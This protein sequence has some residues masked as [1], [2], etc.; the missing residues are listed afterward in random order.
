[1]RD[2]TEANYNAAVQAIALLSETFRSHT[3][4]VVLLEDEE[5]ART[6]VA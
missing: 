5:A 3:Q 1:M 6:G 4:L 2:G